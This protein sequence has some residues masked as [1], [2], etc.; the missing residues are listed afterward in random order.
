MNQ[1]KI[2]VKIYDAL[3]KAIDDQLD[4]HFIRRD[5]FVNH[6]IKTELPY[7]AD[8][9]KGRRLS[10]AARRFVAG[11]LKRM[12]TT[13]VNVVVDK[14]VAEDLN[15]VSST[16]NMVRDAF[17]NRLLLLLRS[18]PRL[19]DYL[20]L[21]KSVVGSAFDCVPEQLPTSPLQAIAAVF[22]DPLYYLRI[23]A[24][25]RYKKGLYLL[26]LPPKFVGFSCYLDDQQVPGTRSHAEL[27]LMAAE[28]L[29]ELE[30]L[31]S[32]GADNSRGATA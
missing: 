32:D 28:F 5:A 20:G 11:E 17:V 13:T 21:P 24:E 10:A 30:E 3:L 25:E 19:L 16:S 7:L 8:D 12:G 6:M 14:Q 23:A 1:T 31:E 15:S 2:T 27:Q 4:K 18:S 22:E 29:K 9:M 26:E